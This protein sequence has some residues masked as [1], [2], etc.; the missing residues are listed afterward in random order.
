MKKLVILLLLFSLSCC[1]FANW[2]IHIQESLLASCVGVTYET[3]KLEYTADLELG[4]PNTFFFLDPNAFINAMITDKLY[5]SFLAY[6][7]M[8]LKVLYK[9]FTTE[10]LEVNAGGTLQVL[11]YDT[12]DMKIPF[13]ATQVILNGAVKCEYNFKQ[14]SAY[15]QTRIPFVGISFNRY[16]KPSALSILTNSNI[17]NDIGHNTSV[18]INIKIGKTK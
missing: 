6:N 13:L 18:G 4:C 12:R 5:A 17:L 3:N 15:V 14:F 1:L 7:A 8:D 11:H 9:A 16:S 2:N 10:K